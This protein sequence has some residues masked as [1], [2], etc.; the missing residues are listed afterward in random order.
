MSLRVIYTWPVLIA[1]AVLNGLLR[2]S[3]SQLLNSTTNICRIDRLNASAR[4][5]TDRI[6]ILDTRGP[7]RLA[8]RIRWISVEN[9]SGIKGDK[10]LNLHGFD[11]RGDKNTDTLRILLINHR[12]PIDPITGE[13]LDATIVG[14]N[15]TIELFQTKAGSDTMRHVRTYAHDLIETP[16]NVAWI[17]D[18]S[19]VYTNDHSGKV[20]FVS[21]L[22]KLPVCILTNTSAE[23]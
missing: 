21:L 5:L 22:T 1:R 2:L 4:G 16:N 8:S 12:P 10:T 17:N 23:N 20:G 6:A 15:S 19:F 18:D 13:L 11:V 14:A 9:F 7:G 3:P